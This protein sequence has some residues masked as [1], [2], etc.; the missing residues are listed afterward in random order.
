MWK[1]GERCSGVIEAKMHAPGHVGRTRAPGH[2][3][4]SGH[5]GEL[6]HN[7]EKGGSLYWGNIHLTRSKAQKQKRAAC[8]PSLAEFHQNTDG[9]KVF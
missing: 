6:G 2:Q 7:V 4:R 8:M 3:G 1:L 5:V 9:F